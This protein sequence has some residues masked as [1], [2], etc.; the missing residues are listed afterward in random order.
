MILKR[1]VLVSSMI[2]NPISAGPVHSFIKVPEAACEKLIKT[3]NTTYLAVYMYAL[4]LYYQGKTDISNGYI[5]DCLHLNIMDVVN[6]FLFCASEGL[7]VVHNFTSV[8][9]AEF[10]V[11]FCFDLSPKQARTDFRPHYR[12][13]EIGKRIEENAKL[14]QTYKIVS[15][16]LGKTLSTS[17]IE[18]LYSMH[19]YYGLTPEVI[20]VLVEYYV[21]KGKTTMRQMEKEAQK[22]SE[23]GIST[24]AKANRFIKKREELLSFAGKV[25]R[26]IGANERKLTTKELEYINKWHTQLGVQIEDIQKAY[27]ITVENTGKVAFGYMNKILETRKTERDTGV[28]QTPKPIKQSGTKQTSRYDY[29]EIMRKTFFNVTQKGGETNGL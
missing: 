7:V 5:A 25:R 9:D 21:S 28:K 12:S 6:A 24:V 2:L 14:S 20:V 10:D 17:D 11:E 4:S 22:W 19:D 29:D 3:G 26:V 18:L 16:I 8:A 23:N 13:G 1:M 15:G 27:E